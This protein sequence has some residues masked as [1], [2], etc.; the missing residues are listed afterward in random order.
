MV[1]GGCMTLQGVT[2]CRQPPP[3]P[4]RRTNLKAHRELYNIPCLLWAV[5]QSLAAHRPRRPQPAG[6]VKYTEY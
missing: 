2:F 3:P 5:S 1:H 6:L 4:P